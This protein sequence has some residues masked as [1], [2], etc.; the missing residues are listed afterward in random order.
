MNCILSATKKIVVKRYIFLSI[1]GRMRGILNRG[2]LAVLLYLATAAASGQGNT[3]VSMYLKKDRD[4][5]LDYIESSS[6]NLF[7]KLGHHGPAIENPWYALRLYLNKEAAIDVYSKATPGLELAEKKWYPSKKDQSEGWGADYYK[8][9][10]TVGLGGIKLWDGDHVHDL[11]PVSKRSAR[12]TAYKDSCSMEMISEGL[13]FKGMEI[14]ILV[15][16]TVYGSKREAKV[17]A[18]SLTGEAVQFVTGINYF[19]KLTIQ[20]GANYMLTWGIHPEDVAAQ[21]VEVGV[22]LVIQQDVVERQLDDGR[23]FLFI[24]EPVA[25]FSAWITSYN[26]RESGIHSFGDFEM[27]V[28]KLLTEHAD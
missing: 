17:E 19:K 24:T 13:A 12:V 9:G 1:S 15:R 2:L 28:K 10:N 26:A 7:N 4:T 5:Q 27:Q 3:S 23:Q 20:R 21:K 11:Q 16:V 8:V 14:D 6:G 22:A 18:F 25:S